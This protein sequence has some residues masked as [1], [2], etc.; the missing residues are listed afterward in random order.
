MEVNILDNGIYYDCK[1]TVP[2]SLS[3]ATGK[4]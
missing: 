2:L 4:V 1:D 3:P